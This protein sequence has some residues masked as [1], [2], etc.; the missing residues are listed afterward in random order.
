MRCIWLACSQRSWVIRKRAWFCLMQRRSWGAGHHH[1][2]QIITVMCYWQ[3]GTLPKQRMRLSE[4][5]CCCPPTQRP[6]PTRP[7]CCCSKIATRKH[8]LCMTRPWL[9]SLIL[10]M[11]GPI[12]G[13]RSGHWAS[14]QQ[15]KRVWR[16]PWPC[17]PMC[18]AI[19]AFV[20]GCAL[21]NIAMKK[22]CGI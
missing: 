11:L 17:N 6:Y 9:C 15:R 1:I 13:L 10:L 18:L 19:I 5:L 16:K 22:R 21:S 3:W 2:F 14:C 8:W 7:I 12:G 20:Q 4:R